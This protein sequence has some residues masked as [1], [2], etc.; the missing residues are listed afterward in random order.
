MTRNSPDQLSHAVT[1]HRKG[2]FSEAAEALNA[3]TA[4][5]DFQSLTAGDNRE[6]GTPL[7]SIIV[8]LAPG[9]DPAL[10]LRDITAQTV[11]DFEIIM[12]ASNT[13][14]TPASK[15][16]MLL[17]PPAFTMAEQFNAAASMARSTILTFLDTGCSVPPDYLERLAA[18]FTELDI[19]ALRGRIPARGACKFNELADHLDLGPAD[20]ASALEVPVNLA[21]LREAFVQLGGFNPLLSEGA[22]LGLACALSNAGAENRMA[23]RP[24]VVIRR[25]WAASEN[26]WAEREALM[27][28]D[29]A[30]LKATAQ[31]WPTVQARQAMAENDRVKGLRSGL[32][33]PARNT[34]R[35]GNKELD[36]GLMLKAKGNLPVL[37]E[38]FKDARQP[39][40]TSMVSAALLK[41]GR[42]AEAKTYLEQ[43][44]ENEEVRLK[45]KSAELLS[46]MEAP[47]EKEPRVHVLLLACD[48]EKEVGPALRELAKTDYS[49]YAIYVADNGSSDATYARCETVLAEFPEHIETHLQR[50]P[51]NI[52][53]PIGHNWLLADHDHSAAEYICIADDD[54]FAMEPGWLTDMVKTMQLFPEAGVVGGKAYGPEQYRTIHGGVRNII[55]MDRE[56]LVLSGG[57]DEL[58]YGQMDYIDMV[59]HVIGCLH[60]YRSDVLFG[61]IGMFDPGLSPCQRV[62][63]DHHLRVRL[64]GRQIIYNGFIEIGHLRSG[65]GQP[66]TPARLG[67]VLGNQIKMLY[68]HDPDQVRAVLAALAKVREK[69]LGQ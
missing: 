41:T 42:Y 46:A 4:N 56:D 37:L 50:F 23:Y 30:Y 8:T 36:L 35:L 20:C 52:G 62:D 60:I 44:P 1:L 27:Q 63:V 7:F 21:V 24:D 59:D 13:D 25:D 61:E 65:G 16:C 28:L 38:H 29:S 69:W 43:M 18:A 67:N 45:R 40:F 64:S 3:Y 34:I 49:N 19:Y 53:R 51:V 6:P 22:G 48:R 5:R 33:L 17:C 2:A 47:L 66:M 12:A 15:T 11:Q 31:A 39:V 9:H 32:E 26:Q 57:K 54:L 14:I 55:W 10:L 58:D 68:K